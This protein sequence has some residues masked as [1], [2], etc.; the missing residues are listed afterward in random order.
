MSTLK[1]V[2]LL[3]EAMFR[4]QMDF[5]E[6]KLS[7][8]SWFYEVTAK[9][10]LVYD[11]KPAHLLSITEAAEALGLTRQM[12]YKY[13]ERGLETV[14]AKGSQ[15]IPKFMVEAWKNPSNAFKMQWIYQMKQ[16]RRLTP[17]QR[18]E[19]MNK[20]I[21]EFEKI[22]GGTFHKLYGQLSDHEIDVMPDAVDICDWKKLEQEKEQLLERYRI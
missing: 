15:K 22:F 7:F 19:R 13:M 1:S 3:S 16:E 5:A 9:G 20:Q 14:G 11:Y 4:E 10:F 18:L 6:L 8:D 2:L 12:I 17:E 21:N